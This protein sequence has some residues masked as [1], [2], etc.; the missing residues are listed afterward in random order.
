MDSSVSPK[1]EFWFLRVCHHISNAVYFHRA[2]YWRWDIPS[3]MLH[4]FCNEICCNLKVWPPRCACTTSNSSYMFRM[5]K[6]AIIRPYRSQDV[7]RQLYSCSHINYV[8]LQLFNFLFIFFLYIRPDDGSFVQPKHVAA[9]GFAAI[10][11]VCQR[12]ASWLLRV[13]LILQSME[14]C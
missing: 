4:I 1:N 14:G 5:H 12:S 6:A 7:K 8:W 10:T 11:V 2:V 13:V 9:L 3:K